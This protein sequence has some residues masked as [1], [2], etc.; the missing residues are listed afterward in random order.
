MSITTPFIERP[1]GTCLLAI[2]ILIGGVMAYRDLPVAEIPNIDFPTIIIQGARPGADAVTM[3]TSVAAP[4]EREL[5]QVAGID[6]LSSTSSTGSMNVIIQFNLDQNI[7]KASH[8]VEAALNAAMADLPGDLPQRPTMRRM[9]PQGRP[10]LQLT[11]SSDTLSSDKVY[12]A[13]DTLLAQRLAQVEGVSQVNESGSESPAVHIQVHPDALK[14]AG[15][16]AG[17]VGSLIQDVNNYTPLGSLEGPE[18]THVITSNSQ[19]LKAADYAD[20]ILKA[21]SDGSVVKLSDVATLYDGVQSTKQA[22]WFNGAPSIIL[23]IQRET[24]A[25][26]LQTT[27]RVKALLPQLEKWLPKGINVT[28]A[29]DQSGNIIDGFHEVEETLL[30]TIVLVVLVVLLFMRHAVPTIA[31]AVTLPLAIAGTLGLMWLMGFSL[32]NFSLMAITISVGFVVDDAIV[33]IENIVR[34]KDMGKTTKQAAIDGANQIAFTVVSITLSLMVVFIPIL[35]MGGIIG[36]LFGQFAWS[37]VA[38]IAVSCVVSLTLTATLVGNF[39]PAEYSPPT[40]KIGRA[41]AVI[42]DHF[43]RGFQ[44]C[45]SKYET[46]LEVALHWPKSMLM[47]TFGAFVAT[48]FLYLNMPQGLLPFEDNGA[49]RGSTTAPSDI[50]FSAMEARQKQVD[51]IIQSDPDVVSVSATLSGGGGMRMGPGGNTGNSGSLEITLKPVS[52][53]S[54]TSTQI[55]ARLRK[56]LAQVGGIETQLQSPQSF[57]GGGSSS[58]VGG[59]YQMSLQDTNLAELRSWSDKLVTKLERTPGIEDVS[60]DQDVGAPQATLTINRPVAQAMGISSGAISQALENS[61]AQRSEATIYGDRNQYEVILEID[62]KLQTS[63]N[64]LQRVYI[65]GTT[66]QTPI[67]AVTSLSMQTTALSVTHDNGYSS[68][69]L[70]Y[71]LGDN[72]TLSQSETMIKQAALEI[73]MPDTVRIAA[74]GTGRFLM[75]SESEQPILFAVTLLAIYVVLGVLYESLIH[76]ITILSTLPS[77]MLGALLALKVTGTEL[78]TVGLIGIIM[79]IGIVKKNAIMMIDFAIEAQREQG[80]EALDAIRQ[81]CIIRFRPIMMT[82]IAAFFGAIPLAFLSGAGSS[83]RQPLGIAVMGG[84]LVSQALTLYTTPVVFMMLERLASRGGRRSRIMT[85]L[86][87]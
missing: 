46:S 31:I 68:A 28:V 8:D 50:S 67:G 25:N 36:E 82:S 2:G 14:A 16:S 47:L 64:D 7:I 41:W 48:I 22:A 29:Q 12:D 58:S 65:P 35:F 38:A 86:A 23:G 42:D 18:R 56:R 62:P 79:L 60:S 5:N 87:E 20:L 1:I 10:I 24:D 51:A 69:T 40:T 44:F 27:A 80:L 45:K 70:S 85:A 83:D 15:L 63:L 66:G 4:L 49:L 13:A 54:A 77:A 34:H 26:L 9:T 6:D 11:L 53:R 32:N 37:L 73:G 57:S 30:F 21:N 19:L 75:Q 72:I 55:I 3:A 78:N 76:P 71:N 74:G 81:A 84:L 61:F 52:Q 59:A 33:M 39:L 43:D 17:D